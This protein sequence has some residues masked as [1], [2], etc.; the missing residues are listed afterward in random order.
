MNEGKMPSAKEIRDAIVDRQVKSEK[1][2]KSITP[3]IKKPGEGMIEYEFKINEEKFNELLK[4]LKEK[5]EKEGK[6]IFAR[7]GQNSDLEYLQIYGRDEVVEEN[8]HKFDFS[9]IHGADI[10]NPEES[11][12]GKNYWDEKNDL[13]Y[14]KC[15]ILHPSSPDFDKT[16]REAISKHDMHGHLCEAI[17]RYFGYDAL[18]SAVEYERNNEYPLYELTK[19]EE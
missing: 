10:K 5:M 8:Y 11:E 4:K 2:E 13:G 17:G 16:L 7:F 18:N 19:E 14:G 6:T 15:L 3:G 1:E 12:E 9:I